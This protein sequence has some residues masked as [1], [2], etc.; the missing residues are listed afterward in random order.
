MKTCSFITEGQGRHATFCDQPAAKGSYC[1][2]HH[3][4]TH[5]AALTKKANSSLLMRKA[6]KGPTKRR[7][8]VMT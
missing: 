1:A 7:I 3:A 8:G 6:L 5:D 4:L 2:E